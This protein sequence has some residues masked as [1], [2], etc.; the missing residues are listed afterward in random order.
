[1]AMDIQSAVRLSVNHIKRSFAGNTRFLKCKKST[2]FFMDSSAA[3][4][5][6][7]G[8][9]GSWLSPGGKRQAVPSTSITIM[10]G[11]YELKKAADGRYHFTLCAGNHEAILASQMYAEKRVAE[12]GIAA[13]RDNGTHEAR[14]ERKLS[15]AGEPYFALKAAN[16]QVLGSSE[17]YGTEASRDDGIRSVMANCPS[18]TLKDLT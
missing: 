18:G 12:D 15:A 10:K 14:Y 6:K 9:D 11:Y 5:D 3:R 7:L 1:M 2:L 8:N 13:V 16:G 4:D 17:V